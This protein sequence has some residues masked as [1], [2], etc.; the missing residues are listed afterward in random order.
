MK[1]NG[2]LENFERMGDRSLEFCRANKPHI[3]TALGI[4]GTIATGILAAQS[5]ARSARKIDKRRSELGRPLTF[6]EKAQLCWTDAVIPTVVGGLACFSE[7]KADRKFSEIISNRTLALVASEKAYE[8]LSQKTKEVLG[9]KKAQQ[10]KDEIAKEDMQ[11]A[12]TKEKLE[13]APRIGTGTLYPFL[14]DYSKILFWSNIDYINLCVMKLQA[15]MRDLEPRGGMNDYYDKKIGV[16]YS[17]WLSYIGVPKKLWN[18]PERK[19]F[20][21]NKGFAA[22]G[23]DDDPIEIVRTTVEYEPG[24]AVTVINWEKNPTDMSL[25]RLIK[26]TERNGRWPE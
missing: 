23:S 7:L 17:E 20:G 22:D 24:F 26:T 19:N 9:E 8:R 25:G 16:P 12:V 10:V 2:F 18:T 6:M 21:W 5:G 1:E 13:E 15:M 14:D 11:E 4:G 3:Y